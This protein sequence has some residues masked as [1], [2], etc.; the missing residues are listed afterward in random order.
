[1]RAELDISFISNFEKT[2]CSHFQSYK[3]GT[4]HSMHKSAIAKRGGRCKKIN[5][6]RTR[7]ESEYACG[8]R[9]VS[10]RGNPYIDF[11]MF[12]TVRGHATK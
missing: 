3:I 11:A 5:G 9:Q 12:M 2:R 6:L 4:V 10:A 7:G 1:M 8:A